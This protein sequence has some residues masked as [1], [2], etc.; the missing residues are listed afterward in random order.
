M[1]N[2]F[3]QRNQSQAAFHTE[4]PTA[5]NIRA[6]SDTF[7]LSAD[8]LLE[9]AKSVRQ[10]SG[11]LPQ[12]FSRSDEIGSDAA[13][14]LN[15]A[16]T[17]LRLIPEGMSFDGPEETAHYELTKLIKSNREHY[18][19]GEDTFFARRGKQLV[20]LNA[21][22]ARDL[23]KAKR[24]I[25]SRK[26]SESEVELVNY[27]FQV[28]ES[29]LQEV[30]IAE[31]SGKLDGN[32][33][34]EYYHALRQSVFPVMELLSAAETK[35]L[36]PVMDGL[37]H[38]T[39]GF[40]TAA[41]PDLDRGLLERRAATMGFKIESS[42]DGRK[43]WELTNGV[44][45]PVKDVATISRMSKFNENTLRHEIM[46]GLSRGEGEERIGFHDTELES[47]A[48]RFLEEAIVEE[49][50][51]FAGEERPETYEDERYA[52]ASLRR[53]VL[54]KGEI[55]LAVFA[56]AL[57]GPDKSLRHALADYGLNNE[58]I[59]K[60]F[61][62]ANRFASSIDFGT[63]QNGNEKSEKKDS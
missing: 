8:R 7:N 50:S 37:K 13:S 42:I 20:E 1:S 3:E 25:L 26:L 61:E 14:F 41:I 27:R 32:G 38:D 62:L 15:K 36:S 54:D 58:Q 10:G 29:M 17:E 35:E 56:K 43:N 49:L 34:N 45:D 51:Q 31:K 40:L 55:P 24:E 23:E 19:D 5:A 47:S 57:F 63:N 60:I 6:G 4:Q 33:V 11:A 21:L 44:Y 30:H 22:S 52:F 46:H 9:K 12:E 2:T 16:N 18:G 39:V 53:N 59:S 28:V 48:G